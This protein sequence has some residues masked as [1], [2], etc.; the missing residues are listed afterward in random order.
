[1]RILISAAGAMALAA[2]VVPQA[3]AQSISPALSTT[4]QRVCQAQTTTTNVF[5]ASGTLPTAP[6][7][8]GSTRTFYATRNGNDYRFV[9]G[10]QQ[11]S[12]NIELRA[13]VAANGDVSWA[14]ISGPGA[15]PIAAQMAPA[16]FS[17]MAQTLARDI[18]ERLMV[19]R[20]F[21]PGEQL[22]PGDL[23]EQII[24]DLTRNFGLP[25]P[26]TGN[27]DVP[28]IGEATS[29][30]GSRVWVWEGRMAMNGSGLVQGRITLGLNA[31]FLMRV[32]HD[33]ETALVRMT[34]MDGTVVVTANG[35]R[36]LETRTV[37]G[38]TCQISP[39]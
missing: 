34:S 33:V 13:N 30:N 14:E 39:Q 35:Q 16:D 12:G 10:A 5:D 23:G 22:Y 26:V 32:E 31:T 29:A 4:M 20:T 2:L 24:A 25:F 3:A 36:T 17:A 18:P 28:Y 11:A 7:T 37:D 19:G 15:A 38:F 1:M 8:E 27:V 6:Q 21:R 9:Q